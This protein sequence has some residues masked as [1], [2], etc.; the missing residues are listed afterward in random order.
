M[1]VAHQALVVQIISDLAQTQDDEIVIDVDQ[2]DNTTLWRLFDCVFPKSQQIALG[3]VHDDLV[4][5]AAAPAAAAA[6]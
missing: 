5:P 2:L 6:P 4:A 3:I 1:P